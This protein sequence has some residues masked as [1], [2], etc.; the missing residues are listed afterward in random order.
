MRHVH[1][2]LA[3]LFHVLVLGLILAAPELASADDVDDAISEAAKLKRTPA[4]QLDKLDALQKQHT[5]DPRVMVAR[6]DVLREMG[7][8]RE[9]ADAIEAAEFQYDLQEADNAAVKS[10]SRDL[11]RLARD[12]LKFRRIAQKEI[13][14]YRSDG[15]TAAR[16][17]L[18]AGR[19]EAVVW[20]CDEIEY[21]VGKGDGELDALRD[22]A[23]ADPTKL[24]VAPRPDANTMRPFS[25]SEALEEAEKLAKR[26][27]WED[28]QTVALQALLADANSRLAHL[29]LAEAL[30][31]QDKTG[32]A[33]AATLDALQAPGYDKRALR[34]LDRRIDRLVR[35]LV[36]DMV[37]FLRTRDGA[38]AAIIK[39]RQRAER[40]DRPDDAEWMVERLLLLAPMHPDV[41]DVAGGNA[42]SRIRARNAFD[43]VGNDTG[44]GVDVAPDPGTGGRDGMSDE[45]SKL[46]DEGDA[47]V[48]EG[49][50]IIETT[51]DEK[52]KGNLK[53]TLQGAVDKYHAALDKYRAARDKA[54]GNREIEELIRTTNQKIFWTK[55]SM[56]I[57]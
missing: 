25:V 2:R 41:A 28:A 16:K 27:K 55:K 37:K 36:P 14:D 11:D 48:A 29:V 39:A 34:D 3:T 33:T 56:P 24:G 26:H 23:T 12:L 46:L 6:A 32:P 52:F 40:G 5:D 8:L 20:I 42:D 31:G 30:D 38:V 17:L 22:K 45:V 49:E 43:G 18:K 51:R 47:L 53:D 35:S 57:D 1:L 54:P 19:P 50:A 10:C 15:L 7:K 44:D 9:A 21:V 4:A 13:A